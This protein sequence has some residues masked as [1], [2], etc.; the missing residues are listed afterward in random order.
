MISTIFTVGIGVGLLFAGLLGGYVIAE[1]TYSPRNMM[2][3]DPDSTTQWMSSMMGTMMNDPGLRQQMMNEMM[4]SPEVMQDMMQNNQMMNMMSEMMGPNT[5]AM[6]MNMF[7][8]NK[9]NIEPNTTITW[10]THDVET[11]NVVGIFKTDSGN[12]IPILSGEIEHMESWNY[13]FEESGIFEYTCG[14]H[15]HEG[16]KGEIIVS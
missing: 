4:D 8:P 9:L 2:A 7:M 6:G 10:E 1:Q 14:Y 5:I 15:E 13:T 16:M 11:H 3:N 12:E